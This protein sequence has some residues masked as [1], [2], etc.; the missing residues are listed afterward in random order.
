MPALDVR[1]IFENRATSSWQLVNSQNQ[2]NTFNHKGHEGTQ[3]ERQPYANS[4]R[5]RETHANLG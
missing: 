2:P 4:I 1:T 3:R 5:M